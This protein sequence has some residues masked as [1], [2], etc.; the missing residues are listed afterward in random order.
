MF[1]F[2]WEPRAAPKAKKR[3]LTALAGDGIYPAI[4]FQRHKQKNIWRIV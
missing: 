4:A 2:H 1:N 3:K